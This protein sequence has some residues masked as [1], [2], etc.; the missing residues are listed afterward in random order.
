VLRDPEAVVGPDGWTTWDRLLTRLSPTTIRAWVASRRLVPLDVGVY[1]TPRA[2]VDW[3]V[4]I[5]AAARTRGAVVSHGTALAVWGLVPPHAGPVHLTVADRRSG[6]GSSAVVLHRTMDP[7][8]HVRRVAGIPVT[9]VERSL[10]DAWGRPAGLTRAALRGAAITAVRERMCR[11][12]D[13]R[14]ELRI[15]PRLPGRAGLVELVELLAQGCRSELEIWGCLPV[16]QAPGMPPFAQQWPVAVGG[17]RMLLDAA[18][19]EVLLAVEM[20][21]AAHHGSRQ[22]REDD[23]RRDALLASAGWQTLR[24]S[25]RRLTSAPEACRLEIKAAYEV[26]RRLVVDGVR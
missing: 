23:I 19:E 6:R 10:V 18:Y 16:L 21:G 15:R 2:A 22:Q 26:R 3:R 20:D 7:S 1:A 5:A 8:W 12:G 17:R 25:Y 4:R 11:P 9:S 13:L 14:E 24:F